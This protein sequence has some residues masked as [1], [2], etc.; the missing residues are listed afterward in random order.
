MP[1]RQITRKGIL[2]IGLR[3]QKVTPP[4]M[5]PAPKRSSSS[6][7]FRDSRIT[8]R[9]TG[10]SATG[11]GRLAGQLPQ[12]GAEEQQFLNLGFGR[13]EVGVQH[14]QQDLFPFTNGPP[15]A[16]RGDGFGQ[17]SLEILREMT[18]HLRVGPLNIIKGHYA[19][20][21]LLSTAGHRVTE[22]QPV[23]PLLPRVLRQ[24]RQAEALALLGVLA[25]TDI[26]LANPHPQN[27]EVGFREAEPGP[28]GLGLQKAQHMGASRRVAGRLSKLKNA[29]MT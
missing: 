19:A 18:E 29:A 4:V 25:P 28:Y 14:R 20:E 6:S 8:A 21:H 9:S 23:H 13:L 10:S 22:E 16:Q 3:A 12:R 7:W 15:R 17:Q 11:L 26:R 5:K 24:P 27:L 1:M 2:R